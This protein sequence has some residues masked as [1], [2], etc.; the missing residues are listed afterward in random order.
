MAMRATEGTVQPIRVEEADGGRHLHLEGR[1]G[2]AQARRLR[3]AA[4]PLLEG[5]GPVTLHLA[6]TEYLDGAALQILLALR[7]GLAARDR[8]LRVVSMPPSIDETLRAVGLG[9]A[10]SA[11]ATGGEAS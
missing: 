1:I 4:L 5:G 9:G 8:D 3:E 6:R 7:E 11:T 10:L 2:V